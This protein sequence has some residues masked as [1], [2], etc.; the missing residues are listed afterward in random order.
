METLFTER[1]R[2]TFSINKHYL[3]SL[4]YD[5][6]EMDACHIILGRPWQYD[7]DAQH[8]GRDN[9]Y[10]VFLDGWMIIFQPLKENPVDVPVQAKKQPILLTKEAEF[11]DEV[12]EAQ[13]ILSL[14]PGK[15]PP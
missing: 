1:C 13:E 9:I 12:K 10:I 2:F 4:L 11:L 8:K 3:D 5:V 7:V 14:V 15:P 6:V